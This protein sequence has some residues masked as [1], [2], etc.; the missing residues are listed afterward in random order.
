MWTITFQN[1]DRIPLT[2]TWESFSR[3]QPN[4]VDPI[5]LTTHISQ[6]HV[7]FP[8][9]VTISATLMRGTRPIIDAYVTAVITRPSGEPAFMHLLDNGAGSDLIAFDGLYS[10]TFTN[11]SGAGFYNVKVIASQAFTNNQDFVNSREDLKTKKAGVGVRFI[12]DDL[13]PEGSGIT[14]SE[15]SPGVQKDTLPPFSRIQSPG[16]F[17][18][19]GYR[20][21]E[22]AIAPSRIIDLKA[23]VE[24]DYTTELTW[25]APGDDMDNDKGEKMH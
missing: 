16:M 14:Q 25:T 5:K 23:S 8:Q 1:K 12:Y 3:E 21:H 9:P 15:P 6:S 4:A 2:L 22:D 24:K 18:V 7:T 13:P 19:T 10:A 11:F 20:A 17:T